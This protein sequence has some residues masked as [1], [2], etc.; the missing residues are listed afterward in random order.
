MST[1]DTNKAVVTL[2]IGVD[3][4]AFIEDMVSGKN[5]NEFMPNRP[6]EIF[7]EKLDSL[8]NVDFVLTRAEA[9]LL[10]GDERVIDVRYGTK[11][12]NGI[13][14]RP[15]AFDAT[16]VYNKTSTL[17]NTHYNWGIPA[18]NTSTNP[19]ISGVGYATSI[20]YQHGYALAGNNV[21]VVIQDSGIQA[22]HPEWMNATGTASRLNQVNW[23]SVSG[24]SGTYT[25]GSNHY[26]DQEGHGTH[27]AGTVAG[28]LYGWAKNAN[29]YAIKIF[30]TDAFGVSASFNMIRAW[31]NLK[32]GSRPTVVNMSWGYYS[33]YTNITGGNYRGT[34]WT[35]VSMVTAYGMIQTL[36]NR[37]GVSPNYV[38]IHPSRVASVEADI[39]DCI[40]A[41]IILVGAAGNEAHKIDIASGTDYNNYFTSSVNGT[42][43]YHRGSTPTAVTGVIN[44]GS[45]KAANPEGRSFFSNVGPRIDVF[46][47]GEAIQSS[48]AAGS[49]LATS[50]GTSDYPTNSTYKITKIS[51]T[52]MAS[53]QVAGIVATMVES[54]P[55]W[56]P[57]KTLAWIQSNAYVNRLTETGTT[58]Y[59]DVQSLL[60]A[61]NRF[62]RQPFNRG[63]VFSITTDTA[64]NGAV[65]VINFDVVNLGG[66][67]APYVINSVTPNPT[68]TLQRG[69]RYTFTVNAPNHPFWIKTTLTLG[70]SDS[71]YGA[72]NQG[73]TSGVMT[74]VVP[75]DAPNT[76]YYVCQYH[77]ADRGTINI[78]N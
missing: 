32:A 66:G 6:V 29:I 70:T 13:F 19:F 76:L 50:V 9:E 68:I 2:H 47:P 39:T 26:T 51:G 71:Y 35:G 14:F 43:Y 40:N 72:S 57:A 33:T 52:S 59:S 30:D 5:H 67:G 78:I 20:D 45:S 22:D 8:R 10:K 55:T 64:S 1:E 61:S 58:T 74:F 38:Y 44:V 11:E 21:D 42:T 69:Q 41:G 53:P 65:A 75:Q 27:V 49:T 34:P 12:E 60:G 62:V 77:L 56:T 36:Y 17:D 3:V 25:Q 46:A 28:K 7:N 63:T 37:T 15:T 18:C 16:R 73:L 31:H 54:R 48:I 23:P 4:D 24:L